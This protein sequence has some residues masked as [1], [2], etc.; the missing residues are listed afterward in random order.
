L[1]IPG[2]DAVASP[3]SF[4]FR[5]IVTG[6]MDSGQPLRGFR[7]DGGAYFNNLLGAV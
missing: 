4:I 1:V 5:I 2:R 6:T 7:N 3:E